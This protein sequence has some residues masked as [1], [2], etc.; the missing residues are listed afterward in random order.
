MT[1]DLA[2]RR[3]GF[4]V[5]S[6]NLGPVKAERF[7]TLL[8]RERP[9]NYTEWRKG[10]FVGITLDRFLRDADAYSRSLDSPA[11]DAAV[12]EDTEKYD[13]LGTKKR[14]GNA[15][16]TRRNAQNHERNGCS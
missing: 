8:L 14:T 7:V 10:L 11:R 16:R 4:R 2:L 9:M 12:C 13:A 6:E 5:L 1:T 3:E 15:A